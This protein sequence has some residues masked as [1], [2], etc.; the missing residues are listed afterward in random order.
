MDIFGVYTSVSA[1]LMKIGRE[2]VG[3]WWSSLDSR[4]LLAAGHAA[5]Y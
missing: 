5:E 4:L 3:H 1:D 2:M